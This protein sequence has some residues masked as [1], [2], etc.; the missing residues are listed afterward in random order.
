MV[1]GNLSNLKIEY[2][3]ATHSYNSSLC[4]SP[5]RRDYRNK[6]CIRTHNDL[7][8]L[9]YFFGIINLFNTDVF[10]L[11]SVI[12]KSAFMQLITSPGEGRGRGVT[13]YILYG[14]DMRLE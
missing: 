5:N 11:L 7:K 9:E 2:F 14:T 12:S 10:A 4:I 1:I 13:P 6:S 3:Q 8:T